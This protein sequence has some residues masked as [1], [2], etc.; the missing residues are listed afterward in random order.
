MKELKIQVMEDDLKILKD[1]HYA[2]C[3]AKS[4]EDCDFNVIWQAEQNFT[5]Q[6]SITWEEKYSIFASRQMKKQTVVQMNVSPKEI[7]TG[8]QITLLAEGC[9]GDVESSKEQDEII[10]TNQW[11]PIYPGLCQQCTG[12]AGD[13]AYAPFYVSPDM[14]IPGTFTTKPTEQ[15]MVWF[16]QNAQSGLIIS[17]KKYEETEKALSN[18][19]TI[20]MS[21]KNEMSIAFDKFSWKK[22]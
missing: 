4:V 2:L 3:I 11:T 20:D 6:N 14:C 16:A 8:Q 1:N 7:A 21:G 15:I 18:F 22:I 19:I 13:T 5:Q 9:F 10:M 17:E 12:F